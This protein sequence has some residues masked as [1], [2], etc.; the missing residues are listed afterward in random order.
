MIHSWLASLGDF[1]PLDWVITALYLV[2]S[3]ACWRAGG[4]RTRE[5]RW[6]RW[7]AVALL[8]LGINKQLDVQ[9][10]LLHALRAAL[11][12]GG[13]YGYK[14]AISVVFLILL[15]AFVARMT[16][17]LVRSGRRMSR[18]LMTSF[19]GLIVLLVF[20]LLRSAIIA[21]SGLSQSPVF[22]LHLFVELSGV[23][24]CGVGAAA[25]LRKRG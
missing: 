15:A 7:M 10:L 16:L 24:L 5:A 2:A 18:G 21:R 1:T 4:P 11:K 22:A 23:A 20:V 13:L 14:Q 9:T 8:L 12:A 25:A 17:A 19:V 6:W 3:F